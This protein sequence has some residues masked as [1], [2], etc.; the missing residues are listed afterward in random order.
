MTKRRASRAC[1]AAFALSLA[2]T[3][4]AAASTNISP[5]EARY[6]KAKAG[7]QT[8]LTALQQAAYYGDV[9]AQRDLGYLYQSG[10]GVPLDPTTAYEYFLQAAQQGDSYAMSELAE[11]YRFGLGTETN[12]NEAFI[13]SK[14]AAESG[15]PIA[16]FNLALM[17][18]KGVGTAINNDE[19]IALYQK[20]AEQGL[21]TAQY[22]LAYMTAT[23]LGLPIDD[24][25]AYKRVLIAMALAGDRMP[26]LTEMGE[27]MKADLATSMTAQQ[28][29][30]ANQQAAAWLAD[31]PPKKYTSMNDQQNF[32]YRKIP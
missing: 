26:K 31:H 19:A 15:R 10:N 2:L 32:N 28:I 6:N 13:W 23:G 1:F 12:P 29:K 14:K 27:S 11:M 22:N 3:M 4:S 5:E 21:A 16:Q 8:A 18:R 25:E 30:Q 7:D 20:S 9:D 17:Y 24:A